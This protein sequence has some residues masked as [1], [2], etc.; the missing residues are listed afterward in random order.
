MK[1]YLTALLAMIGLLAGSADLAL[2]SQTS[3]KDI[4]SYADGERFRIVLAFDKQPK[5]IVK[6]YDK[7]IQ[8]DVPGGLVTPSR[9]SFDVNHAGVKEINFYQ[10][11]PSLLRIRVFPSGS[12]NDLKNAFST[13]ID[14]EKMVLALGPKSVP[15][16]ETLT[17]VPVKASIPPSP[18][19]EPKT[20]TISENASPAPETVATGEPEVP[21]ATDEVSLSIDED[22]DLLA[23]LHGALEEIKNADT[24]GKAPADRTMAKPVSLL[25]GGDAQA[26]PPAPSAS[27]A[28]MKIGSA[29]FIVLSLIFVIAYGAKKYLGAAEGA[30]GAKRQLKVL[31]NHFI[32]VK[33]NVTIVEVGGEILVLGVTNNSINLLARYTDPDKIESIRMTHRLP[34]KPLGVFKKL[35]IASWFA[36]RKTAPAAKPVNPAFA[37]QMAS[38]AETMEQAKSPAT[39]GPEDNGITT[40]KDELVNNVAKSIGRKFRSV[41][42]AAG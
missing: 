36:G 14:G 31:S 12:V 7:S 3:F 35:P 30:F 34:D 8:I 23:K 1:R 38:Y 17:P 11:S 39:D 26:L 21:S 28:F 6:Y 9:R 19:E 4:T 2:A 24:R 27:E 40:R 18:S 10:I 22:K 41:E 29:L 37:R 13:E 15:A 42:E 25:N 16:S 5:P 20:A 32:G 33:K